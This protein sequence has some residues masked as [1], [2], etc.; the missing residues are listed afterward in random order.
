MA[1]AYKRY[2]LITAVEMRPVKRLLFYLRAYKSTG[3]FVAPC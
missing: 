3:L 1:F 2:I